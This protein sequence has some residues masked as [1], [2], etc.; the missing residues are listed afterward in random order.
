MTQSSA[1]RDI[2]RYASAVLNDIMQYGPGYLTPDEQNGLIN[3]TLKAYD[4]LLA[5]NYLVGFRD[6]A[7]WEYHK[8]RLAELGYPVRPLRVM[9]AGILCILQEVVN[10]GQALARLR[11][12]VGAGVSRLAQRRRSGAETRRRSV[13]TQAL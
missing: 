2:N 11:S 7:F 1:S 6:K 5:I 10:P 13:G 3:S 8:G 9:K 12:R 4:R